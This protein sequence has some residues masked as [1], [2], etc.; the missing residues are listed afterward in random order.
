MIKKVSPTSHKHYQLR[1]ALL[2]VSFVLLTLGN[3]VVFTNIG[4]A[5]LFEYG[6]LF[7]ILVG[8]VVGH[9]KDKLPGMFNHKS[10]YLLV[11]TLLLVG[12]LFQDLETGKLFRLIISM[13]I[14]FFIA[15]FP[16]AFFRRKSIPLIGWGILV[17]TLISVMFSL[18]MGESVVT[19]A[20]GGLINSVGF[21]GG[22]EHRNFFAYFMIAAFASFA[23]GYKYYKKPAYFMFGLLSVFLIL[24]SNSRSAML[25]LIIFVVV[26]IVCSKKSFKKAPGL[27]Y[28]LFFLVIFA[29]FS[30]VASR[31]SGTYSYRTNGL[32]NY[33]NYYKD[34]TFHMFFG[35]AEMA[36]SND[37]LGYADTVRSVVGW[38][39]TVELPALN[40]LIKN[41]IFGLVGYFIIFV[42]LFSINVK[43]DFYKKY[44]WAILICF[45]FS[46]FVESFLAN[47][48]MAFTVFAYSFLNFIIS[49]RRVR[50]VSQSVAKVRTQEKG[51]NDIL[52]YGK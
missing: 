5:S 14:L 18:L 35:N 3:S 25:S 33:I 43:K 2:F 23:F 37:K 45:V 39:G 31:F 51:T 29:L 16:N 22:M 28:L 9:F 48:N 4:L 42:R 26:I 38:D 15:V 10:T 49:D 8:I 6:G 44:Y 30:A 40:I 52:V 27:F 1:S 17:G 12:L 11:L 41:G 34:D 47:I 19:Q 24:L 7:I 20:E 13:I 32:I 50:Y 21:S 46:A 36:F